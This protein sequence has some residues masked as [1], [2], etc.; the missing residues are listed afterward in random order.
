MADLILRNKEDTQRARVYERDDGRWDADYYR[1][2]VIGGGWS[3]HSGW[4]GQST[5]RTKKEV[6]DWLDDFGLYYEILVDSPTEGWPEREPPKP[7]KDAHIAIKRGQF[8]RK[9]TRRY[10]VDDYRKHWNQSLFPGEYQVECH[11]YDA[12]GR[13]TGRMIV[14]RKSAGHTYTE[15]GFRE[16]FRYVPVE[17]VEDGDE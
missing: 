1:R 10:L 5:R 15:Q 17:P 3:A 2:N 16:K 13:E 6:I 14:G 4:C 12:S 7:T 11:A 9:G 8:W